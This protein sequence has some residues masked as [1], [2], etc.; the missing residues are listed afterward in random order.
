M[1]QEPRSVALID[2]LARLG[3]KCLWQNRITGVGVVECWATMGR[4]FIVCNF[5]HGNGFE[6]YTPGTSATIQGTFDDAEARLKS[7]GGEL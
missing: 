6:V 5:T 2:W 7:P 4:T 1:P 3:A